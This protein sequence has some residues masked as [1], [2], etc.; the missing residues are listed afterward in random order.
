MTFRLKIY[1]KMTRPYCQIELDY[2]YQ[3]EA[4]KVFLNPLSRDGFLI[5][6]SLPTGNS[7]VKIFPSLRIKTV[8]LGLY[9]PLWPLISFAQGDSIWNL[10][11]I[12]AK[13]YLRDMPQQ[14]QTCLIWAQLLWPKKWWGA[15][16]TV[17]WMPKED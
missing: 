4:N 14:L 1:L 12:F 7:P 2:F 6:L 16:L 3:L 11:S 9:L 13:L 8:K 5:I 15:K 10:S 17:P